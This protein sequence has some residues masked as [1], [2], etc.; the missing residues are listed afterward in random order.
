MVNADKGVKRKDFKAEDILEEALESMGLDKPGPNKEKLEV[1]PELLE[2]VK[3]IGT[4]YEE[5]FKKLA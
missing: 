4:K 1:S 5:A 2:I 3:E